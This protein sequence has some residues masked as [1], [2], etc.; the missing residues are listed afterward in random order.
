MHTAEDGKKKPEVYLQ[1]IL[2][3][4]IADQGHHTTQYFYN[5]TY[6]YLSMYFCPTR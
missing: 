4:I 2:R 1:V 5:K 6:L 3:T